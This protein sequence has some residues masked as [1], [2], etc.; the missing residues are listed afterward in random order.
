MSKKYSKYY[1]VWEG[2]IAGIYNNWEECKKQIDGF[3]G[4]KYKSYP[5]Q[6]EAIEAYRDG[7]KASFTKKQTPNLTN[8]PSI[9][10]NSICVDAA[11]SG[12][13]GVMEYRGVDFKTRQVMF[14]QG[15]FE[16]GTNNIGEFLA[17]VQALAIIKKN[18]LNLTIYTDSMTAIS[19]V[20][21]KEVKT[22]LVRS[23]KNQKL[24]EWI[25]KALL[26]LRSNSFH[27]PI[28]KW[29]TENWGEIPADFGRK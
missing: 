14:H 21:K 6:E 29:D 19:W 9:I 26:W 15:P 17:L 12:N 18:N 11:C 4:A 24:F 1:V 3:E 13:P 25:E 7:Y 22:N 23:P 10:Q 5:S 8:H 28:I 27:T 2:R 16:E 20:R